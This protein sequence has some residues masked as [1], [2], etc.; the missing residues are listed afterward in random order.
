[1]NAATLVRA[2]IAGRT[3]TCTRRT[4]AHLL[5]TIARLA[6]LHPGARLVIIQTCYNS[7]VSASAGTHDFDAVLDVQIVGLDWWAAQRFLRAHG[8]AA[9]V[10]EPPTFTW[11]IHMASLG[12]VGRVGIFVPGQVDDY[13]RHAFGLAGQHETGSDDSWFPDDIDATIFDFQQWEREM[14]DDM[15]YSETELKKIVKDAVAEVLNE[16]VQV[17]D[18]GK[19]KRRSPLQLI[20]ETWQNRGLR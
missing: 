20:K 16:A 13:Y 17:E 10:R 3:F 1:M 2:N 7:G 5:W 18:S 15:P 6:K 4:E 14:E 11:H 9:W 19:V 8:W 12:Y